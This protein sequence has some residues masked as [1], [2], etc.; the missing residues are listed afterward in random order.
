MTPREGQNEAPDTIPLI[1]QKDGTY[2]IPPEYNQLV[3]DGIRG[4]IQD[5][6][7]TLEGPDG[8]LYGLKSDELSELDFPV[9]VALPPDDDPKNT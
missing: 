2:L 3:F 1:L 5:H 4:Y 7:D 8:T 9:V 6:G